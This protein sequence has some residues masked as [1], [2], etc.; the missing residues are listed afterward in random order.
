MAPAVKRLFPPDSSSGAA[1]SISTE[2]PF[3][4]AAS[5]A[6]NAAFPPPTT[7]TSHSLKT[8]PLRLAA[9][10]ARHF[11]RK[12]GKKRKSEIEIFLPRLRAGLSHM[13]RVYRSGAQALPPPCGEV[14]EPLARQRKGEPGGGSAR[15]V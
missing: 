2:A 13:A 5:A 15:N 9:L 4:R 8:S 12:R 6:Q 7:M 3:S 11:P 1:S 14:G 10:A